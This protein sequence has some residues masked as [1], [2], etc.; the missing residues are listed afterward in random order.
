MKP[1]SVDSNDKDFQVVTQNG[2]EVV[3]SAKGRFYDNKRKG[4]GKTVLSMSDVNKGCSFKQCRGC[5]IDL[6]PKW[7]KCESCGKDQFSSRP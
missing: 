6:L 7:S 1:V 2:K 3:M 4:M 5:G